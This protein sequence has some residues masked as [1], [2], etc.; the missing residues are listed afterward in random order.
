VSHRG[1]S[2]ETKVPTPLKTQPLS[3][4]ENPPKGGQKK[5]IPIDAWVPSGELRQFALDEG[6]SAS[7]FAREMDTMRDWARA[8]DERKKDWDAAAR[9]WLRR[10]ANE[11]HRPPNAQGP[12]RK[13]RGSAALSELA[14]R[15]VSEVFGNTFDEPSV[16][17]NGNFAAR[18]GR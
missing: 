18:N 12:P 5:P 2:P 13:L 17:P 3:T 9:N 7:F 10:G 6:I 1:L 8:K 16:H 4:Q 14:S 15:P 11:S